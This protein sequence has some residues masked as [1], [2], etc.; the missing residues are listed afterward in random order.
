MGDNKHL[1]TWNSYNSKGEEISGNTEAKFSPLTYSN[2]TLFMPV[3]GKSACSVHIS[4]GPE[5]SIMHLVICHNDTEALPNLI[6]KDFHPTHSLSKISKDVQPSQLS[7]LKDRL[8]ARGSIILHI[9]IGDSLTSVLFTVVKTLTIAV[10]V[11]TAFT[12]QHILAVLSDER[13][14]T[15]RKLITVA[16]VKQNEIPDNTGSAKNTQDAN[17][18][19]HFKGKNQR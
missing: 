18:K 15:V 5:N 10:L 6:L 8:K 16:I 14:V 19:T 9:R 3:A 2:Q 1:A 13:R 4:I 12:D 17:I 11:G 7:A